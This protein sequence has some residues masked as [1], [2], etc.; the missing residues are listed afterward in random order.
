MEE[1][2]W[3]WAWVWRRGAAWLIV[4]VGG[5]ENRLGQREKVCMGGGQ[6]GRRWEE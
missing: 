3:A 4:E 1:D 2:V 5:L 6:D